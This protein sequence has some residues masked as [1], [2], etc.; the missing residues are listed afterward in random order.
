MSTVSI[1]YSN[2]RGLFSSKAPVFQHLENEKPSISALSETQ[3]N[4][5][6][7]DAPD[8]KFQKYILHTKFRRRNW[9]CCYV[10]DNIPELH[11]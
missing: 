1:Q 9:V 5:D 2:I 3:I 8:L 10:R 4:I 6:K 11:F 7:S